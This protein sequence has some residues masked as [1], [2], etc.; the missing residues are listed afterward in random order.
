MVFSSLAAL[1]L[2]APAVL[3]V[4][5]PSTW[6]WLQRTADRVVERDPP[7]ASA[8][9]REVSSALDALGV[10]HKNEVVVALPLQHG[11]LKFRVDI[12]LEG[13]PV[14]IEVNGAPHMLFRQTLRQPSQKQ[15]LLRTHG[16]RLVEIYSKEW[17]L[18]RKSPEQAAHFLADLLAEQA[19]LLLRPP[20]AWPSAAPTVRSD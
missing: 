15:R 12:R 11:E 18:H 6:R 14:L 4:L 17:N 9:H 20:A 5:R 8:F 2:E 1:E 16:Y 10:R 19:G 13:V 7:V 3:P